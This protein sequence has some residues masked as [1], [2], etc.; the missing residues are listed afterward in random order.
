MAS[1][2]SNNLK[3]ELIADGEK[4]GL[5]GQITNLN[6]GTA[7]EEAI[8]GIA[9]V[10]FGSDADL[11]LI[12][13]SNNASQ[14]ARNAALN[15]V[16]AVPLT[17]TRNLIVPTIRK[18]YVVANFT[19]GGQSIVVKT[20][21]GTGVTIPNGQTTWLYVDGTNVVQSFTYLP[22]LRAGAIN[23]TPIGA[24]TPSTGAFTT[25]SATGTL[26]SAGYTG[27]TG[28]FTGTLSSVG[29]SGTTGLFSGSVTFGQT[30]VLGGVAQRITGDFSNATVANRV[31]FQTSTVN[32]STI[33]GAIPNGTS[34]ITDFIAYSDVDTTN[35]NFALMRSIEGSAVVFESGRTG[36]QSYTP[37]AFFTGGLERMRIAVDGTV[38]VENSLSVK[39]N[40]TLGD[41]GTDTVAVPSQVSLNGSVGTAGQFLASRGPNLSPEWV[42]VNV[43][44]FPAG[45]RMSFNQTAA[46]TGWTKDTNAI[47]NDSI[48]RIVTGTAA[49][50]GATAFSTF[51]GQ[52]TVGATTL[53][54]AQTPSHSHSHPTSQNFAGA[55]LTGGNTTSISYQAGNL[56][57]T[58][59]NG[60][61]T[62]PTTN[63]QGGGGSHSHSLTTN[64]KFVDFIIASKD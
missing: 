9:S 39:G 57:G 18:P 50:G 56:G 28:S 3:L 60:V 43:S 1:T 8:V 52:T 21:A 30:V 58:I 38:T 4:A 5:W 49:T 62:S 61:F 46:P 45:T 53:A 23:S 37:M 10:S 6:L 34:A 20:A 47:L 25:L 7:L 59:N 48:L 42:T 24:T 2:Y 40:T 27:T 36:A 11:T 54:L 15:V 22:T 31:M 44:A 29:Y 33:V 12:L 16:S 64:I 55:N 41:A 26:S 63:A 19:T 32:G 51:N 13:T 17:V 14:P 35:S